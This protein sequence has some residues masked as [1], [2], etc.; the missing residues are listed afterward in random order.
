[1]V[2]KR[3]RLITDEVLTNQGGIFASRAS[4]LYERQEAADKI[5]RL[6]GLN[7]SVDFNDASQAEIQ[8]SDEPLDDE[9]VPEDE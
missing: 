6:F 8:A 9:E 5:N 4:R 2:N 1:M 3:E 7:V